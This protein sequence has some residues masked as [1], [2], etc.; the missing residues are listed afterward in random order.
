MKGNYTGF[1]VPFL[2][3]TALR[4]DG[5]CDEDGPCPLP[6]SPWWDPDP[7]S[8]DYLVETEDYS[9]QIDSSSGAVG[10]VVGVTVSFSSK[11][12]FQNEIYLGLDITVCHDPIVAEIIG[13]PTYTDEFL[14]VIPGLF[15]S[16][17]YA[18]DESIPKPVAAKGH[19]FLFHANFYIPSFRGRFPSEALLPLMTVY[20]R[21]K[22]KPG[23]STPLTFCDYVLKFGGTR[24]TYNEFHVTYKDG[25]F[26]EFLTNRKTDGTLTVLEGPAT[27][28][29]PPPSPP[30][31]K[32]YPTPPT[33]EEA[34]FRIRI[35]GTDAAEPIPGGTF[36]SV[37][38]Y[39][40]AD[41]EYGGI[42][43]PVHF[44]K[45]YLQFDWV[46]S[47]QYLPGGLLTTSYAGASTGD[48]VVIY[49]GLG[50]AST[51]LAAEGEEVHVATLHFLV[52][53]AASRIAQTTVSVGGP[54]TPGIIVLSNDPAQSD[55]VRRTVI[56]AASTSDGVIRFPAVAVALRGDANADGQLD[57]SDALVILGNL[58]LG[59]EAL[60][61][62][63]AGDF[64]LDGTLD[65]TDPVAILSNLFLGFP[66][67]GGE[68]PREVSCH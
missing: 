41:V 57:I 47:V 55:V 10:D 14:S 27:H 37:E 53:D 48:F 24:C 21:L 15:G 35:E 3:V 30:E 29:D 25:D 33:V 31:A 36:V 13:Q 64:N 9:L 34:N 32:V 4:N 6:A 38:V 22:G 46:G 26:N 12:E 2:I 54:A 19:G 67:P 60:L 61:C 28:P 59:G 42:V 65:L 49:S 11:L 18:V 51:R 23:D 50:G 1:M 40:T 44:D 39:A 68:E 52:L 62:P 56:A 66:L 20:Y 17:F 7:A 16:Q 43:V 45:R 58:F 8:L 5:F 63:G